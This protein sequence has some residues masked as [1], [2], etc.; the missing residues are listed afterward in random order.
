MTFRR[1]F[2]P[3]HERPPVDTELHERIQRQMEITAQRL[4]RGGP[5]AQ[6]VRGMWREEHDDNE[7]DTT[8]N[9]SG[10]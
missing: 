10:A 2:R 8:K 6:M 5:L 4:Q 9:P 1:L 7:Q 3:H